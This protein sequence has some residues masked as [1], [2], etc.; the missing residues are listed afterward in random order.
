MFP[1]RENPP[2]CVSVEGPREVLPVSW[3]PHRR[4]GHSLSL[5]SNGNIGVQNE[6]PQDIPQ[7]YANY[8]ELKAVET[9]GLK[10]NFYPLFKISRI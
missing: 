4:L 8:F 9:R 3:A 6:L 2:G 10:K 5:H 7:W 1:F